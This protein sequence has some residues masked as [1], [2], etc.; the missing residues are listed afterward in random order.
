MK[1]NPIFQFNATTD[2]GIDSVP[3]GAKILIIDNDGN[4]TPKEVIKINLGTLD[5]TSTIADFLN[6][7]TLYSEISAEVGDINGGTY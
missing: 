6:D 3:I 4:G 5:E 2:T 1:T 7:S